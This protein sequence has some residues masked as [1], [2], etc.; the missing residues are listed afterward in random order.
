MKMLKIVRAVL[1]VLALGVSIPVVT[2]GAANQD[3]T[4]QTPAIGQSDASAHMQNVQGR[5]DVPAEIARAVDAL[6]GAK[7]DLDKAGGEWGGHKANA[8]QYIDSAL[9]EIQLAEDYAHKHGT[10]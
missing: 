9:K 8:I 6:K 1:C 7:A 2:A 10:Y 3:Q 4:P 5:G